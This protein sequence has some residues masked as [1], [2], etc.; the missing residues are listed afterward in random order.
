MEEKKKPGR[1]PR[2]E[3]KQLIIRYAGAK[4]TL[5]TID[6]KADIAEIMQN[7][8]WIDN[9]YIPSHKIDSIMLK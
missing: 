7:G 9:L 4:A 3:K 5:Q 6:A 8:F 2:I 1:P